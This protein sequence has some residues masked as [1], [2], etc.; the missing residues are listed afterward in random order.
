LRIN[1]QARLVILM[2]ITFNKNYIPPILELV[3]SVYYQSSTMLMSFV[4]TMKEAHSENH[5]IL[6]Y[7]IR[8]LY[9]LVPNTC[10]LGI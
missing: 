7:V 3:F 4:S 9:F 2:W 5:T 10:K 1:V 6:T 8:S